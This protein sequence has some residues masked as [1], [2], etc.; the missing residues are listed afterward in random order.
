MQT[1]LHWS[2]IWNPSSLAFWWLW[3]WSITTWKTLKI[4]YFTLLNS[5]P[6]FFSSLW[7]AGD[8]L[9]DT[10]YLHRFRDITVAHFSPVTHKQVDICM[11]FPYPS[12]SPLTSKSLVEHLPT[13]C[14]LNSPFSTVLDFSLQAV[15]SI[16]VGQKDTAPVLL[17]V[18][19]GLISQHQVHRS[20]HLQHAGLAALYSP[21][22]HL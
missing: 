6:V 19:A 13:V 11:T 12:A 1:F 22:S 14:G 9:C 5:K 16:E 10:S 2:K 20:S 17:L 15:V 18:R 8:I 7:Y 21:C 3:Y 4:L